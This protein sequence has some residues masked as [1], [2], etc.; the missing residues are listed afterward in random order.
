MMNYCA[1]LGS[2]FRLIPF[3]LTAPF[4]SRISA[5]MAG[6]ANVPLTYLVIFAANTWIIESALPFTL[7]ISHAESNA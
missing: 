7:S 4:G 3:T 6:K 5:I 2:G 1:G